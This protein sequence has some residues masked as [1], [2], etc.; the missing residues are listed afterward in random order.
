MGSSLSTAQIQPLVDLRGK[1]AIVPG[2]SGSIGSAVAEVLIESGADV[3]LGYNRNRTRAD[4]LLE[5]AKSMGR[6]GR[7]DMVDGTNYGELKNWAESA[8]G[9]FGQ[10]DIIANCC[11]YHS[12]Q[13]A[14]F[15]DQTPDHWHELVE[16][17]LMSTVYL[18]H[19]LGRHMMDRRY[20]RIIS[21]G[22]DSSKG[23]ETGAA[24]SAAARGG[25]NAFSKSLARE[26]GRHNVTVNT[27]NPGPTESAAY[28]RAT[29]REGL[30]GKL[31]R[32]IGNRIPMKRIATAR[33]VANAV[34]FLASDAASFITG[35]T[36][37]VSG[38]LT[39]S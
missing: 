25:L 5:K 11:G 9:E 16:I 17:E 21:V 24:L 37:S 2:A 38:G 22:S 31:T 29:N 7:V 27:V 3:I 36:I 6:R 30:A 13:W 23:G 15:L 26:L 39:M 18:V 1:T 19:A 20:G 35:Q 4:E 33:E 32:A 28:T 12:H 8:L 14:L 34:A 10:V